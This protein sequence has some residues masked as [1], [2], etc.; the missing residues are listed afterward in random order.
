FGGGTPVALAGGQSTCAILDTG[1]VKCWGEGEDGKLGYGSTNDVLNPA[2]AP[3]TVDLGGGRT[4]TAIATGQSQTCGIVDNGTVRCWGENQYGQLGY[5]NATE[6]G[7][8]ESPGGAG[9]VD[10]GSGRTAVAIS[11][12]RYF[13][14]ALLDNG[15][16]RCWGE[17]ANGQLGY[18][19]TER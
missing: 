11:A 10:L 3:S 7:D 12:G 4:A 6:I 13:T 17:G 9:P 14:C 2:A 5:G 18:G 19:S 1:T 16:V 8:N 15:T